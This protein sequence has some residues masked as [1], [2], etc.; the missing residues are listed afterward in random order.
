[1]TISEIRF[2]T[3]SIGIYPAKRS[4]AALASQRE[5][6]ERYGAHRTMGTFESNSRPAER[7]VAIRENERSETRL[8]KE[9]P[10]PTEA[11]LHEVLM[12][13][14]E[15]VPAAD[16]GFGRVIT[17]GF[18]ATLASGSADLVLLDEDGK[19]CIV[20]VKKEGNPDTRRVVAQLL[21]YAAALWGQTVEKFERDVFRRRSAT[22]D[23][24]SLRDF[25]VGE[26][27]AEDEDPEEAADRAL[28]GLGDTLKKGDFAL[29]VAA[30]TIPPRVERVIEYLNAGGLSVYGLEV[31]YFTGEV[32]VFVPRVVVRPT[33]GARIAGQDTTAPRGPKLSEA[34]V[35]AAIRRAQPT[36]L[37]DRMIRLYERLSEAGADPSWGRTSVT[38]WLGRGSD[39]PVSVGFYPEGVAIMFTDVNKYRSRSEQAR[40]VHLARQIPG[41]TRYLEGIEDKNYVMH[42]KMD[43]AEVLASDEALETFERVLREASQPPEGHS[44]PEG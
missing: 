31:S 14:P 20:E 6:S 32:D 13:R 25:L 5:A 1:M 27:F 7:F 37:A 26:L 19:V 8:M 9:T 24:R 40:L 10:I 43:P 16:L 18:E 3:C 22:P 36:E 29:V 42:P 39:R 35:L 44:E 23:T 38:M 41:V 17:A 28:E 33:R 15:L 12:R 30:P 2:S 4:L 11:E 34:D 21:D